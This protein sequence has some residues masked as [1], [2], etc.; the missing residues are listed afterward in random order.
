[1]LAMGK[2]GKW[3]LFAV[4]LIFVLCGSCKVALDSLFGGSD[5]EVARATSPDGRIDAVVHET[6]GGATTSFGYDI[7]LC[8]AG[9]GVRWRSRVAIVYGAWRNE[10]AYGVDLRWAANDKLVIQYMDA[11]WQEVERPSVEIEGR[12]VSVVL[13]AGVVNPKELPHYMLQGVQP[14]ST[15]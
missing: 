13:Q 8:P 3:L 4:A 1:M 7:Y 5:D 2:A 10:R 11:R 9:Q 12:T 14:D 15:R 6:N